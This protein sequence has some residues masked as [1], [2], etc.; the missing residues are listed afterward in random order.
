MLQMH[1]TD[2][3]E[4]LLERSAVPRLRDSGLFDDVVLCVADVPENDVLQRFA[5]AWGVELWRGAERDV[6][7]RIADLA[8]ERGARSIARALVWWF[9]V[10]LDLVA[11]QLDLLESTDADW[12]DLPRDFDLRFGVDAFRPRFVERIAA[13]LSADPDLQA[14]FGLA[15]WAFAEAHPEAFRVETCTAVPAFDEAAFEHT[16]ERMRWLWPDRWDGAGAA[17]VPY[18]LACQRL[19]A[20]GPGAR[21]LDVASGLGAG[22]ARMG[23]V[24]EAVG[25]DHDPETVELAR[26]RY[27]DRARFECGDALAFDLPD[28]HFDVVTSI[29]TMEHVEDDRAFLA[30]LHRWT[31]PGGTLVLE[32][33]FL[34]RGPFPDV[35]RPLS[36]DHVR[37]YDADTLCAR[38]GERFTILETHGVAR[39]TYVPLERARNAGLVLARRAA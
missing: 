29:H 12:V 35:G 15:P 22:T 31:K 23:G 4:K 5:D 19:R 32:V 7:R 37:E 16:R 39:G 34:L 8:A 14:R 13:A 24:A 33:P 9:F 27:A 2:A 38:V 30:T 17:L 36:P 3:D 1:H 10:D 11:R 18:A 25:L 21:V 26:S 20:S 6:A 28:A